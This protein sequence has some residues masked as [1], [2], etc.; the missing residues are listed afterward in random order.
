MFINVH[1]EGMVAND[2][3]IKDALANI[4]NVLAS[5]GP[6]PLISIHIDDGEHA[7]D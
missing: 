1:I 7:N 3:D 2:Q 5:K 4:V 6:L